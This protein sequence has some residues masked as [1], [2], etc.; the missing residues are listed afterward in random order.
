VL[1][2]VSVH[3]YERKLSPIRHGQHLRSQVPI[4][5]WQPLCSVRAHRRF[6]HSGDGLVG[7]GTSVE[8]VTREGRTE[9]RA[10]LPTAKY[11]TSALKPSFKRN[12]PGRLSVP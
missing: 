6:A 8:S 1:L 10:E 9:N 7:S 12:G 2:F 11:T 5:W 4:V 3:A